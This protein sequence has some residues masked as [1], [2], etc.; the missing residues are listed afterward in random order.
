LS[1]ENIPLNPE[2][3]VDTKFETSAFFQMGLNALYS[4]LFHVRENDK[5]FETAL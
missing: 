5:V 4:P 1:K 3:E 2:R